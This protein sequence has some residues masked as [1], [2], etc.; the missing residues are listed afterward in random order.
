MQQHLWRCTCKCITTCALAWRTQ[1]QLHCCCMDSWATP[2]HQSVEQA[3]TTTPT[4]AVWRSATSRVIALED[5]AADKTV[6]TVTRPIAILKLSHPEFRNKLEKSSDTPSTCI[7]LD[8]AATS[9][10]I[11][12]RMFWSDFVF[13]V[14][15]AFGKWFSKTHLIIYNEFGSNRSSGLLSLPITAYFV[16]NERHNIS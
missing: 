16:H 2:Q 6:C 15:L 7:P 8:Y 10:K 9:T 13:E 14:V 11:V 3:S 12:C 4:V 5:I 1:Q